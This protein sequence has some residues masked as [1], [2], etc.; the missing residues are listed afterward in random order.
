MPVQKVKLTLAI[1]WAILSCTQVQAQPVNSVLLEPR[2][3]S[4]PN[5]QPNEL[6]TFAAPPPPPDIGEPGQRA[7]A[8]SRGCQEEIDKPLASS[9]K[10]LLALMP[11]YSDSELVLGTT[12]APT[13]TFWFYI[14]YQ[15]PSSGKFVLR[16]K[17]G[18][19]LYHTDVTLPQTSGVVSLSLPKAV[20]PLEIGKQYHWFLKIY[21]KP[22]EPPAYVE[23]WIQ[24]NPLNPVLNS[25]LQKATPRDLVALYAAHGIWFEAL[26]TASVLRHRDPK[27]TT[28]AELLRTV[29]LNDLATEPILKREQVSR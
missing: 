16:D 2:P 19:L 12:I 9:Q 27:D 22:Q 1:S 14:P 15:P 26:S 10:P 23:G 29:G 13:P 11:V 21:C 7:E 17:N 25:Q 18:K 6:L 3:T 20:A 4:N 5:R 24:R 28:W 8:G